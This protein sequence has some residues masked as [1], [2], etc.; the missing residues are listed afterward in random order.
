MWNA[1]RRKQCWLGVA[2]PPHKWVSVRTRVLTR[3]GVVVMMICCE[4]VGCAA[5]AGG[6][7][8]KGAHRARLICAA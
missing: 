8:M 1:P 6:P 4:S 7:A 2:R 5:P 3:S